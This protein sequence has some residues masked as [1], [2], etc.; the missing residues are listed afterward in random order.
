MSALLQRLKTWFTRFAFDIG[1]RLRGNFFLYLAAV[2]TLL[3][4]IDAATV[5]K[6]GGMRQSNYDLMMG[7]RF[8]VPA[9]SPDIVIVDID[10]RT[11]AA[12]APEYG[13]WPWPRQVLAEFIERVQAQQP[14][15]IVL[16]IVFSDADIQNPDSDA[17]FNDVLAASPNVFLTMVRLDNALDEQ[18]ALA[19]PLVP[20]AQKTVPEA[21]DAATVA[22]ILPPFAGAQQP[23]RLG[24]NNIVPDSDG[25]A[26]RYPVRLHDDGWMLPGLPL[27]VAQ[28][29]GQ[30]ADAPDNVL[31][32]WRGT[33]KH[34]RAYPSISFSDV[35][36]DMLKETPARPASEFAGK[37]LIIGSTAAALGDIKGTPID[38]T[39]PG[40]EILATA[41]DNV[42]GGDW[43]RAPEAKWF[44]LLMSLAVIWSTAF[45]FY[46]SGAG[47]KVDKFYGLS[48]L[49]LLGFSYA[50]VNLGNLYINLTGPVFIGAMYFAVAR[51][52]AFATER[53]MD[54]SLVAR[55]E[56]HDG[57]LKGLLVALHFPV[58][59]REEAALEKLAARIRREVRHEM[60]AE[61]LQGRQ[62]GLW[63]LFE[64]TLIVCWAYDAND[65]AAAQ[66]IRSEV[67]TVLRNLP[68]LVRSA[69]VAA[70]LPA[71]RVVTRR[72]EGRIRSNEPG[73]WRVLFAATL[74]EE[75]RAPGTAEPGDNA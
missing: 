7:L 23:G 18:S 62:K 50:T 58:E 11:L 32:N 25:V 10:E 41:I 8:N 35:Y 64:N 29:A 72:T 37:T 45:A 43:I 31:I 56:A 19:Y 30:G 38:A 53:A 71:D 9:P 49:I 57:Q 16:D 5:N 44:Y 2:F 68:D 65:E 21:S 6:I 13:R 42:R 74:L 73:D 46:R 47:T 27:T 3:V 1:R 51:I 63:R 12:M 40:V 33:R 52:Y 70:A 39:F 22:L 17:Y 34:S 14:Q 66:A 61:I 15:A 20:G 4:L 60:S 54:T 75:A 59:T 69:G 48:A 36:L 55:Y 24:T 28:A 26:R 67:D